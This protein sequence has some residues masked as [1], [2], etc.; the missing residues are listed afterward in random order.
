MSAIFNGQP[1]A[2]IFFCYCSIV[3]NDETDI[4]IF[5]SELS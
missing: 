1:Y 3:T 5:Y 2:M 4:I